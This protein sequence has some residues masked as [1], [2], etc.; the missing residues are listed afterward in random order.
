MGNI[1]VQKPTKNISGKKS[2]ATESKKA[3][4]SCVNPSGKGGFISDV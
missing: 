2:N 3:M 1:I 4:Y